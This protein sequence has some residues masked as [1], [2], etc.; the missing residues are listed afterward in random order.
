VWF[1]SILVLLLSTP[2]AGLGEED[3]TFPLL[4]LVVG[5]VCECKPQLPLNVNPFATGP[6]VDRT[7]DA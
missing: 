3:I 7:W 2:T 5:S 6:I 1:G 4:H